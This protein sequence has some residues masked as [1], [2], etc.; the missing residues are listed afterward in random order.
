MKSFQWALIALLAS[1]A[2]VQASGSE[3]PDE[4]AALAVNN[5]LLSTNNA[6]AEVLL[7]VSKRG[8]VVSTRRIITM[9]KRQ[10]GRTRSLVEFQA[11]ADVAGAKFLSVERDDGGTQQY[12]YLPAFKKVKRMVGAQRNR[13]FMGT[14]FSFSDLE[15]R[16]VEDSI[17]KRLKDSEISKVPVIVI[18][19]RVKKTDSETYGRSVWYVHAKTKVPMRIDFFDVRDPTLLKKQFKV[20][21]LEKKGGRWI[22]TDSI[23]RTIKKKSET[24]LKLVRIDFKTELSDAELSRAALER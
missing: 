11:P 23:M 14:D 15:G 24:R 6:K 8:K 18:E 2:A 22:A 10:D 19:G 13:S 16:K 5:N 17:W 7:E 4:I 9:I 20:K 12:L 1:P 3:T 21:R